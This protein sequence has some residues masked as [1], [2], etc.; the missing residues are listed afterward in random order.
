MSETSAQFA[1]SVPERIES[2]SAKLVYLHLTSFGEATVTDLQETLELSRLALFSILDSLESKNLV[3]RT[4]TG[5]A[6]R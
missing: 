4:E 5:Y 2:P 6:C 1:R 3:H